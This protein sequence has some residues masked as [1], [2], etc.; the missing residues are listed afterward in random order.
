VLKDKECG[1]EYHKLADL[2][3]WNTRVDGPADISDENDAP[4]GSFEYQANR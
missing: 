4:I 1:P 2:Y 3:G